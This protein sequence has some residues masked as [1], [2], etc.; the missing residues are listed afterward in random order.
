MNKVKEVSDKQPKTFTTKEDVDE[1]VL[2]LLNES[3]AAEEAI[4]RIIARYMKRN[5]HV[6]L[7]G[8]FL[9]CFSIIGLIVT[10]IK[11]IGWLD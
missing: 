2:H 4:E 6:L 8:L 9:T 3:R 5:W 7:A 10:A 11:I 1:R